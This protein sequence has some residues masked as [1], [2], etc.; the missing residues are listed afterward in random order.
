MTR[1]IECIRCHVQMEVGYVPDLGEGRKQPASL[2]SRRGHEELL[3][4]SE[5]EGRSI[6][7]R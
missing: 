4:R 7:S 6:G 3:D 5:D 2:V 1:A